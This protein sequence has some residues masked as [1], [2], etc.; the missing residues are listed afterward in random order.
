MAAID[1]RKRQGALWRRLFQRT[2]GTVSIEL[3]LVTIVLAMVCMGTY[4]FARYGIESLRVSQA[5]R[6]G[7][8][9]ALQDPD[10]AGNASAIEQAVR[11][12]AQ[13][14]SNQLTI[15]VGSPFCGC[16]G[17]VSAACGTTCSDGA[18][19]LEYVQL[20]VQSSI[21]TMFDL[22]GIPSSIAISATNQIR[23]N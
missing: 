20:T 13:D 15:T 18:H 2:D 19:A 4:D 6:A 10:N 17:Q 21:D 7:L 23:L 8:Q 22:P 14:T 3:A 9:Y 5:A 16:P 12:D 11:N 1:S